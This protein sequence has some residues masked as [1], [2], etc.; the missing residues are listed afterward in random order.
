MNATGDSRVAL[1]TGGA[2]GIGLA[3]ALA[4]RDAGHRVAVTY[5]SSPPEAAAEAGLLAVRCDVTDTADVEAAFAAVEEALDRI[6]NARDN[7]D[8]VIAETRRVLQ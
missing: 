3:C 7:L 1:V 8:G 4:L 6:R 2:R 5:R